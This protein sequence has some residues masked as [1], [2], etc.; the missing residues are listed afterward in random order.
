MDTRSPPR[1]RA[2]AQKWERFSDSLRDKKACDPVT[3]RRLYDNGKRKDGTS[4]GNPVLGAVCDPVAVRLLDG[5][6]TAALLGA[7]DGATVRDVALGKDA[8][9]RAA[10]AGAVERVRAGFDRADAGSR[11]DGPTRRGLNLDL[12]ARM[13]A[14]G[15]LASGGGA[16]KR[17]QQAASKASEAR[18]VYHLFENSAGYSPTLQRRHRLLLFFL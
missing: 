16:S 7:V 5:A 12:Y 3:G 18:A 9:V 4:I 1:R 10:V 8:A 13:R 2:P 11:D 15:D 17:D 6:A 14:Y